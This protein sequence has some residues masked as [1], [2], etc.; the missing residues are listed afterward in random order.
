MKYITVDQLLKRKQ[1]L[2]LEREEKIKTLVIGYDN[3]IAI[4]EELINMA[5]NQEEGNAKDTGE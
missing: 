2:I 3:A 4:L 1:E 5:A